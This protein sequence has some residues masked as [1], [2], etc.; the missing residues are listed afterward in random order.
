MLTS[1]PATRLTQR[2]SCGVCPRIMQLLRADLRVVS[3]GVLAAAQTGDD[4]HAS[5]PHSWKQATG[6]ADYQ[7]QEHGLADQRRIN[8]EAKDNLSKARTKSRSTDAVE[9]ETGC[10]G[11]DNASQC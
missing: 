7:R 9:E 3:K 11:S 10:E 6:Q 1:P 2:R 4:G 8:V 5:R